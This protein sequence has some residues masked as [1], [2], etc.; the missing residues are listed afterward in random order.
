MAPLLFLLATGFLCAGLIQ[1]QTAE[2]AKETKKEEEKKDDKKDEVKEEEKALTSKEMHDLM[3][4]IET[5]WNRLKIHARNKMGEKAALAADDIAAKAPTMLRYDGKVL[6]GDKK[7]EKARDQKDYKDWA[8]ALEKAA[9]E[10]AKLARKGDWD[11]ADKEKEKIST[12]CSDCHDPYQ[13][14]EEK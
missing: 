12:S 4:E 1:A 2:K 5:A 7:G 9:K 13:P 10:Y 8:A 6:K 14:V 11:K 3:E